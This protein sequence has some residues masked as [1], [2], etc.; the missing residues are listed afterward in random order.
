MKSN[1]IILVVL[2]AAAIW[3]FGTKSTPP[4]KTRILP[5][6]ERV[7]P[8]PATPAPLPAPGARVDGVPLNRLV[9][10]R[11]TVRGA[12]A[13]GL[14]L[15]CVPPNMS[16]DGHQMIEDREREKWG[17][18]MILEKG[19]LHPTP[20]IPSQ[21][22]GGEVV[23]RGHPEERRFAKGDRVKIVAVELPDLYSAGYARVHAYT[24]DFTLEGGR[25]A[26]QAKW[27]QQNVNNPLESRGHR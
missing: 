11:G 8:G 23:L 1:L 7:P 5:W 9:I 21:T 12:T 16:G 13:D 3:F 14:I 10:V 6:A 25:T 19:V 2:A 17:E 18:L 4:A 24:A 27:I 15:E 26:A 20:Y 22:I